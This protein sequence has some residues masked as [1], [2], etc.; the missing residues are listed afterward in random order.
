M[1]IN[2][3]LA[4]V[5]NPFYRDARM[6][7]DI[8]ILH[9]YKSLFGETRLLTTLSDAAVLGTMHFTY[10]MHS[11]AVFFHHYS[12]ICLLVFIVFRSLLTNLVLHK[13]A[14]INSTNETGNCCCEN[15][16]CE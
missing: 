6:T 16:F 13:T 15:R 5:L 1:P 3:L 7:Y 8:T 9:V 11:S 4:V 10:K 12:I 14:T 2:L